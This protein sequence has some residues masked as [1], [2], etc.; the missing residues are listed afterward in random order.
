MKTGFINAYCHKP[1][2]KYYSYHGEIR[3]CLIEPDPG[4]FE[5][6]PA[7]VPYGPTQYMLFTHIYISGYYHGDQSYLV[8]HNAATGTF[9]LTRVGQAYD[10]GRDLYWDYRTGIAFDTIAL[11][12]NSKIVSGKM[13]LQVYRNDGWVPFDIIMRNGMPTFPH[14]YEYPGDYNIGAYWGNGGSCRFR[15]IQ[16]IYFNEVGVGWINKEGITKFQLISSRDLGA[17]PPT[18]LEVVTYKR[19]GANHRLEVGY[20][21]P[22]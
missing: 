1:V 6:F 14:I 3:D 8:A 2:K 18:G 16:E 17:V 21:L 13:S 4:T 7:D 10:P 20:K 9:T 11:P 22:L 5:N 12:D 19:T 15:E